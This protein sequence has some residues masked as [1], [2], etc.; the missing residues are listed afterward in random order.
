MA[1]T[2]SKGADRLF[3]KIE[4]NGRNRSSPALAEIDHLQLCF[5]EENGGLRGDIELIRV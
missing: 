4:L 1:A 5:R 2:K 3:L